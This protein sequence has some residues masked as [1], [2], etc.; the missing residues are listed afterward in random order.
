M[1]TPLFLSDNSAERVWLDERQKDN[2]AECSGSL[3][4]MIKCM[5][6]PA[7]YLISFGFSECQLLP[8]EVL[9]EEYK[10]GFDNIWTLLFPISWLESFC[11]AEEKSGRQG[12]SPRWLPGSVCIPQHCT[13]SRQEEQQF[14]P[15]S[16]I[17]AVMQVYN[18]TLSS[19]STALL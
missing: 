15:L 1:T 9:T 8:L 12:I 17:K 2:R 5:P 4:D 10:L 14:L 3:G 18:R 13:V 7:L 11:S 16:S 19:T 6:I